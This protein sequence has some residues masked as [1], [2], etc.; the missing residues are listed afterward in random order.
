M[1]FACLIGYATLSDYQPDPMTQ[2]FENQNSKAIAGQKNYRYEHNALLK[3][4]PMLQKN[5]GVK[6]LILTFGC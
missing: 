4:N 6:F 1:G 5:R 2:I 3:I